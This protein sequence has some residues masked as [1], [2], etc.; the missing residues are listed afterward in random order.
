MNTAVEND[1][2]GSLPWEEIQKALV[3]IVIF[4]ARDHLLF[5]A[6]IEAPA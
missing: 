4:N 2:S 3:S 6:I 1:E 5:D